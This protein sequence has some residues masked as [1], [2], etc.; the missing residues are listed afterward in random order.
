M[1]PKGDAKKKAPAKPG[2]HK[3]AHHQHTKAG[4]QSKSSNK[5]TKASKSNNTGKQKAGLKKVRA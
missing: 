4:K 3:G 2:A 5:P 1:H